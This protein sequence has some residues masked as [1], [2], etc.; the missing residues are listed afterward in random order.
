[1]LQAV[2]WV[3]KAIQR[4][5]DVDTVKELRPV[6]PFAATVYQQELAVPQR[7]QQGELF[8]EEFFVAMEML[9]A[10]VLINRNLEARDACGFWNSLTNPI[11]G[12]AEVEG[13]NAQCYFDALVKLRQVHGVDGTFPSWN[14]L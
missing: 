4:G 10:I 7:Q 5:V 9:S 2:R 6:Y 8:Q 14:D 12:L 13:E 11:T 3:N 1:M